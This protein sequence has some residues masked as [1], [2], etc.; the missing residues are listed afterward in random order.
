MLEKRTGRIEKTYKPYLCFACK[1]QIAPTGMANHE[2]AR[3]IRRHYASF[4]SRESAGGLSSSPAT[5]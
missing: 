3:A 4:H 1:A 2:V 5:R